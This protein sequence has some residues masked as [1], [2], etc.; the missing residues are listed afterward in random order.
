MNENSICAILLAAGTGSRMKSKTKKQF[1][2]INGLPLF[3][4]S[5]KTMSEI[6]IIDKIIIVTT[7]DDIEYVKSIVEKNNLH[8]VYDVVPGGKRRQDS[9][10]EGV[11]IIPENYKHILIHDSARPFV[12]KEDIINVI[13]NGIKYDCS[14]LGVKVKDT[15]REIDKDGFSLRTPDREYLISVQTPQVVIRDVI[16]TGLEKYNDC[17]FTDDAG[18][19][20]AMGYK[21]KI[22]E[23]S[24][25]NIKIT[26]QEDL[27]YLKDLI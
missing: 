12:K 18:I 5:A 13:N 3:Y 26:T 15:I 25:N 6:D 7:P 10:K 14:V 20:E 8:K 22:T 27:I 1:I 16:K 2:D 21:T 11:N 19:M 4:Y 23:G 9:V 17:L 24:Y